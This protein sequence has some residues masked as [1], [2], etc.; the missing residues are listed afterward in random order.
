[1]VKSTTQK[2]PQ[3]Q[4]HTLTTV[5]RQADLFTTKALWLP[6]AHNVLCV[7]YVVVIS[8]FYFFLGTDFVH[9]IYKSLFIFYR[10]SIEVL[11]CCAS[12]FKNNDNK[13]SLNLMTELIKWNHYGDCRLCCNLSELKY[14]QWT[15]NFYTP[16]PHSTSTYTITLP[17]RLL[18]KTV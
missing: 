3:L 16:H 18:A 5:T 10:L 12:Q 17:L 7:K 13:E 6:H 11:R 1:M 8:D 14:T 4:Y 2:T 15:R 9:Y